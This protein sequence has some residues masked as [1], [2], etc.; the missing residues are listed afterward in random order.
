MAE[1]VVFV[2]SESGAV[3]QAAA[4]AVRRYLGTHVLPMR[5][6]EAAHAWAAVLRPTAAL[7]HVAG[8]D[9]IALV[10]RLTTD[11]ETRRTLVVA[12]VDAD[13]ASSGALPAGCAALV[14][15]PLDSTELVAAVGSCAGRA[16]TPG[17]AAVA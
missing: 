10:H 11:P 15:L 6:G 12:L 2:V 13:G 14:R 3:R 8:P 9:G 7:V 1:Q 17:P 5:G 4:S 16:A